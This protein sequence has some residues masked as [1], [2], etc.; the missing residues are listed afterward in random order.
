M[1]R[2]QGKISSSAA[3]DTERRDFAHV[4]PDA[5]KRNLA[6]PCSDLIRPV[7]D[8][9]RVVP[10]RKHCIAGPHSANVEAAIRV[11]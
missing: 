7:F 8:S 3:A 10:I 6:V 1:D 2:V 4:N 5:I 11:L 9:L